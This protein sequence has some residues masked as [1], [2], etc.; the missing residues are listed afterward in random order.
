L[1]RL[2]LETKGRSEEHEAAELT[3]RLS[4]ACLAATTVS[5]EELPPT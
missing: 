1:A 3:P 4:A 2:R 5:K